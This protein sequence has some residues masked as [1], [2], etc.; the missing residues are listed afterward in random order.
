[1]IK[2]IMQPFETQQHRVAIIGCGNVGATI[3][4]ALTLEG[5]ANELIL[6]SRDKQKAL[7]EKLDIEHGMPFLEHTKITATNDYA[8]IA[9]SDMVIVTAGA[10]QKPGQTRLDVIQTNLSI[11]EE[12][13][14]KIIQYVPEAVILIVSNPVDL[15]TYRAAQIANNHQGKIFGSGTTLDTS[16]FRV[17]LAEFLRVNP[18]SIHAY[19]LGEHGDS[20]FHTLSSATIGGQSI[21]NVK[22]YS[23]DLAIDAFNRAKNAAYQIINA[24]GA[25]YYAIAVV[26]VRITRA[27]LRDSRIVLPVSVP[28]SNYYNH[29]DIS[30]SVPCIIGRDGVEEVLQIKLSDEEQQNLANSVNKLKSHL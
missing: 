20:S 10:K 25:T 17:H 22:G 19:I 9:G 28:I 7:G 29:K 1:M 3:A 12:L 30:L 15:L 18:I 26:A 16:R 24:K 8:D 27:V 21:A 2:P 4:F 23:L 11:I 6:L 5:I 14:P 13:I